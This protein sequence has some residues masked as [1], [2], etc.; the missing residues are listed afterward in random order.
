[1]ASSLGS[2][3]KIENKVNFPGE[4]VLKRVGSNLG[5][6]VING[7]LCLESLIFEACSWSENP[8]VKVKNYFL[9]FSL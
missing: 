9:F 8:E 7:V 2:S 4:A 1:M 6:S 3:H 5:H